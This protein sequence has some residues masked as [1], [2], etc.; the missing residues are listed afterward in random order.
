MIID[1]H[2][3]IALNTEDILH[4]SLA[5]EANMF[6]QNLTASGR[7]TTAEQ[8]RNDVYPTWL[9]PAGTKLMKI[10]DEAGI[11]KAFVFTMKLMGTDTPLSSQEQDNA[12][13]AQICSR[14]AGRLIPFFYLHPQCPGVLTLFREGIEE[15]HVQGLKLDPL[16]GQYSLNDRSIYPF[17]ETA[18]AHHLPV[19]VHTGARP[20]DPESKLAHPGLLDKVL[21]DFP[22]LII[23]AAH[24]SF[25]WWRELIQLGQKRQNLM[26]DISAFQLTSMRSYGQFCAIL[27]KVIDGLGANRIL[28]GSD[29]PVQ[30]PAPRGAP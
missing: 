3:H 23:I 20:E 7:P 16:A 12:A 2:C 29:G 24:M 10:M 30:G 5:E 26:T 15:W 25:G 11:D 19:L 1:T 6:A 17:Y 14:S 4:P 22:D 28:F 8:L 27:R 18:Q 21:K 13:I 9:D